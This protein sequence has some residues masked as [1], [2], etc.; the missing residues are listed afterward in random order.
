[1]SKKNTQKREQEKN[2]K[3]KSNAALQIDETNGESACGCV[4]KKGRGREQVPCL[5]RHRTGLHR[6]CCV[7]LL[8]AR[9]LLTP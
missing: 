9:S 8:A 3:K 5:L 6:M 2:K 1:M 4:R 7:A